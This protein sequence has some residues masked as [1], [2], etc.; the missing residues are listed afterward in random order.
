L[1]S[2]ASEPGL[3][4]IAMLG[5]STVDSYSGKKKIPVRL[6][7]ALRRSAREPESLMVMNLSFPALGSTSYY[8]LA[9]RIIESRPDLVVWEVSLTHASERWRR[10]I[11]R[12]E[13]A[14]WMAPRRI[15]GTLS[16]PIQDI[17][18]TA[19][20]LFLYQL[21]VQLE[22]GETW[23]DW[24]VNLSRVD[25][26][27][28]ELEEWISSIT[29]RKP[30]KRFLMISA[31][32]AMAKLREGGELDRYN[33]AGEIE[34]FGKVLN[35]IDKNHPTLRF[36][37]ATARLFQESGVPLFV[38]LNPINIEHLE[39]VGVLDDGNI[40]QTVDAF[41]ASVTGEGVRFLDL[42][43]RFPDDHFLDMAGHFRHD[44]GFEAQ[45]MLA[46]LLADFIIDEELLGP[47]VFVVSRQD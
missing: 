8:F 7:E 44:D 9:D 38:Y 36:I 29:E 15:P 21:I 31:L 33:R 24:L 6:E 47:D 32:K 2:S 22:A 34:H 4:R 3:Q 37:A 40:Q 43:D 39:K 45:T 16:M 46:H 12:P 25:K 5:D 20:E 26:V 28:R 17:G 10:K 13:L 23:R 41:R 1:A 30:E 11:P 35:G 19:D 27:R 42:H 14:G 18:L